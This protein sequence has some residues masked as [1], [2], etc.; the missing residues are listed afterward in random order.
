MTFCRASYCTFSKTHATKSHVCGTCGER[1]HGQVECGNQ[2]KKNALEQFW[3]EE[4]SPAIHC[5]I[6]KDS[7]RLQMP[8]DEENAKF[9]TTA[10]HHCSKCNNR[11]GEMNV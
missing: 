9:H 2:S 7:T 11:H 4:L 10:S 6:C 5:E 1:G 8:A 3:T